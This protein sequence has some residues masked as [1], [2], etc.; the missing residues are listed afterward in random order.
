VVPDF[1]HK[2]FGETISIVKTPADDKAILNPQ[3]IRDVCANCNNVVLSRLDDYLATLTKRYF[4]TIIHPGDRVRFEYN[5]VLLLRM[6]LKIIYNIVRTRGWPVDVFQPARRFILGNEQ[7]HNG[8]HI[9]LQLLIPTPAEKTQRPITPGTKEIPPLP[10]HADLYDVSPFPGLAFAGSLSFMSYRFLIV[11]ENEKVPANPRT[12]SI[13]KWLK[14]NRGTIE[15]TNKGSV[16][17]YASSITV[18]EALE[19]DPTFEMQLAKARKLKA[20]V[21]PKRPTRN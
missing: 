12:R 1:Y 15:L 9:F 2:A 11:R 6:L 16:T 21:K 19:A 20:N 10:L 5:F 3:E 18:L 7:F 13:A 8:F 4:S 17:V 14:Q